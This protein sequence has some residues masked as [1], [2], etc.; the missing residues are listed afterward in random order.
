MTGRAPRY[1]NPIPAVRADLSDVT[2]QGLKA[3][4]D[5]VEAGR[6]DHKAFRGSVGL[7]SMLNYWAFATFKRG[8]DDAVA[9]KIADD[10]CE[11]FDGEDYPFGGVHRYAYEQNLHK[12]HKTHENK[13]RL[14]W[15]RANL[16]EEN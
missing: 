3:W 2:R 15:V 12:T 1:V 8:E 7:C 14:A 5:W 13:H 10:L 16:P 4:L 11:A 6:P 9:Q